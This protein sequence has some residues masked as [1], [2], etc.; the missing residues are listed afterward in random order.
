ML[1]KLNEAD[2]GSLKIGSI[3][4]RVMGYVVDEV[5]VNR[6]ASDLI[7]VVTTK[8]VEEVNQMAIRT[9]EMLNMPINQ[10]PLD[11]LPMWDFDPKTGYEIDE[12]IAALQK[13]WG[14]P[15]LPISYLAKE[16]KE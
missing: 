11:V 12:D 5:M 3:V 14:W 13:K 7:T 4:L 16:V 1:K 8:S 2:L 6:V 9:G 15:Q 10:I